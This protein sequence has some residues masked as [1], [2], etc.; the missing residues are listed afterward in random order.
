MQVIGISDL[1]LLLL[2]GLVVV[3]IKLTERE[4]NKN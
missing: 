1:L 4:N 2:L 3:T